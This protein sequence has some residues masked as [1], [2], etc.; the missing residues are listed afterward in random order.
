MSVDHRHGML[1]EEKF[2]SFAHIITDVKWWCMLW[3]FGVCTGK[4]VRPVCRFLGPS[5]RCLGMFS[6]VEFEA[7]TINVMARP[8]IGYV[9]VYVTTRIWSATL[10]KHWSFL[11]LSLRTERFRQICEMFYT[12]I[13]N[14]CYA[15]L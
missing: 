13:I 9:K 14:P 10:N 2:A 1:A 12:V 4:N 8:I 3:S 6:L 7:D 5:W 11:V 15:C